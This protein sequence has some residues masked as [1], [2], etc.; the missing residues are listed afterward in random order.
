MINMDH[1]IIIFSPA[2]FWHCHTNVIWLSECLMCG[3]NSNAVYCIILSFMILIDN[4]L[5]FDKIYWNMIVITY[6]TLSGRV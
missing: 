6:K 1:V 2:E 4:P 5:N 3:T